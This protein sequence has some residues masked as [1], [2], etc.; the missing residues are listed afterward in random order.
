MA[1]LDL[2][3]LILRFAQSNKGEGKSPKTVDWYTEMLRDFVRFI[4]SSGKEAILA[5]GEV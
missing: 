5:V 3:K 4:R 1:E 2:T